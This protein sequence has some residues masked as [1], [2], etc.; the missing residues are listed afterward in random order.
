MAPEPEVSLGAPLSCLVAPLQ[1]M[2]ER[3]RW[4]Q[5]VEMVQSASMLITVACTLPR[6]QGVRIQPLAVAHPKV[7]SFSLGRRMIRTIDRR[8]PGR[9]PWT[10]RARTTH[11]L[12][13][14]LRHGRRILLKQHQQHQQ[15]TIQRDQ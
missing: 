12:G 10:R 6:R 7:D 3:A 8:G 9:K 13:L 15:Q 2:A 5:E 1:V 4:N 11:G 14:V